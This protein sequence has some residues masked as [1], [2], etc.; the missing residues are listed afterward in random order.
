MESPRCVAKAIVKPSEQAR[1]EIMKIFRGLGLHSKNTIFVNIF[2]GEVVSRAYYRSDKGESLTS[3]P[4]DCYEFHVNKFNKFATY[5]NIDEQIEEQYA[6]AKE[7]IADEIE[8]LRSEIGR[9]MQIWE[10]KR[11]FNH[12][13]SAMIERLE[14]LRAP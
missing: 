12:S 3:Q 4:R 14:E 11:E 8:I 7:T 5:E 13:Q 10:S 1:K 2:S 9:E 6:I